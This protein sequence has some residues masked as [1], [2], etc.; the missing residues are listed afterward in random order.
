[1]SW[2]INIIGRKAKAVIDCSTMGYFSPSN[3]PYYLQ[4]KGW[5]SKRRRT[6]TITK[7]TL[8]SDL[9]AKQ[10]KD[11]CRS[12]YRYTITYENGDTIDNLYYRQMAVEHTSEEL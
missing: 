7:R 8:R 6:G 3:D 10:V 1:M 9:S 4:F 11:E 2:E 5:N 12:N